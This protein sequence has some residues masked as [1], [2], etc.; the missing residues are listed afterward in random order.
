MCVCVGGD[1]FRMFF[2]GRARQRENEGDCFTTSQRKLVEGKRK[3][4][5]I[6]V[7]G[8]CRSGSWMCSLSLCKHRAL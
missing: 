7:W 6:R 8:A 4:I 3:E 5:H 1:S 2:K